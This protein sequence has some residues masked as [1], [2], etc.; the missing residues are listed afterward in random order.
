MSG[1]TEGARGRPRQRVE[2]EFRVLLVKPTSEKIER[3]AVGVPWRSTGPPEGNPSFFWPR[4]TIA[5]RKK[6][7]QSPVGNRSCG[8]GD[9][10]LRAS[11]ARERILLCTVHLARNLVYPSDGGVFWRR[12]VPSQLWPPEERP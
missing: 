1:A 6:G 12:S 3:R 9:W 7:V 11:R 8:V 2:Q 4:R 10:S 5:I